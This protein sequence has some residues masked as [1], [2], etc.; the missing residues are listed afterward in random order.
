MTQMPRLDANICRSYRDAIDHAVT[1]MHS[2]SYAFSLIHHTS[3]AS[4]QGNMENMRSDL[5]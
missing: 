2:R 5:H 1:I 3:M 4:G